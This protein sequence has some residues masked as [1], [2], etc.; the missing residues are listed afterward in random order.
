VIP[1]PPKHK[2]RTADHVLAGRFLAFL[3]K[4]LSAGQRIRVRRVGTNSPLTRKSRVGIKHCNTRRYY[5]NTILQD[6]ASRFTQTPNVQESVGL[7]NRSQFCKKRDTSQHGATQGVKTNTGGLAKQNSMW[8]S[9][10]FLW[11]RDVTNPG[12]H[13]LYTFQK[14]LLL[15]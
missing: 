8:Q 11:K 9:V 2:N 14:T 13:P 6:T 15:R 12:T 3:G 10:T 7:A 1:L 5:E 4:L